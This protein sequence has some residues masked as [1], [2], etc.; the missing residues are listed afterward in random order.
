[1]NVGGGG[2]G[3]GRRQ[4]AGYWFWPGGFCLEDDVY[5]FEHPSLTWLLKL[6]MK[7]ANEAVVLS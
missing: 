7:S 6:S 1:M 3:G 5:H 4:M 2:G